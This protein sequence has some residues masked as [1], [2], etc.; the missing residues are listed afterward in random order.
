MQQTLP[1]SACPG[2]PSPFG[3]PGDRPRLLMVLPWLT[4]G[5]SDK[6]N[7]DLVQQMTRRGWDVSIATTLRGD[8]AW[9]P[10]F[11]RFTRDIFILDDGLS[12]K[13]LP[14]LLS[15]WIRQRKPHVVMISQSELGYYLL[16]SW[17]RQFPE[18]TFV[19][20]CHLEDEHWM[21]GGFPRLSIDHRA[22]LDLTLVT[23]QHLKQWMVERGA[24]AERVDVCTINVD[25]DAWRP[26]ETL[27]E[28]VRREFD[29]SE[30]TP[31]ILYAGRL[32][33]QKQPRVFA[34][35]MKGLRETKRDFVALVAGDGEDRSWLEDFLGRHGLS[36]CA[37]MLGEV[38]SMRVRELMAAADIFFLP[39]RWEGIALTF[40]EAMACGLVVVGADVGGQRELVTEECGI[41]VP[42]GDTERETALYIAALETLLSDPSKRRAM[43]RNARERICR[44]FRLDD[45]G[46]NMTRLLHQARALHA[47]RAADSHSNLKTGASLPTGNDYSRVQELAEKFWPRGRCGCSCGYPAKIT[48]LLVSG[49]PLIRPVREWVLGRRWP[50]LLPLKDFIKERAGGMKDRPS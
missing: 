4:V 27:R 17:R 41:L 1:H 36:D 43:G 20:Y 38:S 29:L 37:R 30:G 40:Y 28:S 31:V 25:P 35:V 7:L 45:M 22:D 18:T 15:Q 19:D 42:V 11:S 21:N 13:D 44:H 23:S 50:W 24:D 9:L 12:S 34:H 49:N 48:K 33:P 6:F 32:C 39:S 14:D 10:E 26:D 16:P 46:S 2:V 5:G 3:P 47:E 8:N